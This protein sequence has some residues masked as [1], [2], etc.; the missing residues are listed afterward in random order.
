MSL[1]LYHHEIDQHIRE[2]RRRRCFFVRSYATRREAKAALGRAER[3]WHDIIN[4]RRLRRMFRWKSTRTR[5]CRWVTWGV[6]S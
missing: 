3:R 4:A 1:I 5:T 2:E 6:Y